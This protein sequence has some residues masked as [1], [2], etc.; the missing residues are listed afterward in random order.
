MRSQCGVTRGAYHGSA[1]YESRERNRIGGSRRT[2]SFKHAQKTANTRAK[3]AKIDA[4]SA[5]RVWRDPIALRGRR[6]ALQAT[7]QAVRISP[8]AALSAA[9]LRRRNCPPIAICPLDR[10]LRRHPDPPLSALCRCAAPSNR[11]APV[12]NL[13]S[14]ESG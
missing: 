5:L 4:L 8:A 14:G 11:S 2:K 10:H 1:R 12:L 6:P 9:G 7:R 3:L 13:S